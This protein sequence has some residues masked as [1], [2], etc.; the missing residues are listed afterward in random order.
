V[1]HNAG[2]RR[3]EILAEI[4]RTAEENG[5]R[6]VGSSVPLGLARARDARVRV[7]AGDFLSV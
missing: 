2:V 7:C 4:R 1:L 3:D 5:G 6:L